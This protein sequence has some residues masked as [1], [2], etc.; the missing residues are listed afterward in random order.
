MPILI[1]LTVSHRRKI[2]DPCINRM[3]EA[4]IDTTIDKEVNGWM[5]QRILW[6]GLECTNLVREFYR[7]AEIHRG[8]QDLKND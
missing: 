4:G 8:I 2:S 6:S 7:A 3:Q 1:G 5:G